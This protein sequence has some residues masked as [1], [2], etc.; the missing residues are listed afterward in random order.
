MI[1]PINR[2]F[3]KLVIPNLKKDTDIDMSGCCPSCGDTKDR[4]H[5]FDPGGT[6][7]IIKCFNSGCIFEDGK[8]VLQF[9]YLQTPQYVD[10]YKQETFKKTIQ[11]FKNDLS[12]EDVMKQAKDNTK[13]IKILEEEEALPLE[14]LFKKASEFPECVEYLKQRNIEVGKN[15][16]FS[17]QKFFLFKEKNYYLMDYLI[18]PIFNSDNLYKGFY[19]RSIYEKK[20]STFLLEGEEKI[21]IKNPLIQ[22]DIICEGIF[23]ALS[24]GFEN[25]AAMLGSS[26]SEEYIKKLSKNII[27]ATDNDKTGIKKALD[28]LKKGFKVFVWPNDIKEKD[29]NEMLQIGYNKNMIKQFILNNT[30][31]DLMGVVK[32]GLKDK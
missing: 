15:W 11:G 27:F 31:S 6:E 19:S 4:L 3:F 13:N 10:S 9:L 1:S 14:N 21:W 20:F 24:S 30:Y 32:L 8:N 5:L 23:D 7:G 2:K 18:I 28:F 25:P 29:F 26:L 12:L 16:F 22:P 17:K